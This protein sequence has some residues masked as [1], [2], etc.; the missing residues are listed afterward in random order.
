[1]PVI[2]VRLWDIER[3]IRESI[4]LSELEELLSNLKAE[5]VSVEGDDIYVEVSHDRA[6]LFSAEGIARAIRFWKSIEKPK[7]IN[8]SIHRDF[9]FDISKAPSYRPYAFLMI[10]K[11]VKLDDESIRQIF[12]LQ[13]K[14]HVTYCDD[15]RLVSI[16]LY[17]LDKLK[18][19]IRYIAV[20]KASFRPLDHTEAMSLDEILVKVDKGIKYGH[21]V[22]RGEY[23]LLVD[24]IGN[25]LSFPPIINCEDNRVTESTK[26]IVVDV[27]GTEPKLMAKII[28]LISFNVAERGYGKAEIELVPTSNEELTKILIDT[29]KYKEYTVKLNDI[30]DLIGVR[31]SIEEVYNSLNKSGY[32]ARKLSDEEVKVRV[33]PYRIDVIGIVD[34]IEDI[35]IGYG[36]NKIETSIYPPTH[37][38]EVLGLERFSDI[39]RELMVGLGFD[40]VLNF[41][42]IDRDFISMLTNEEFIDLANPKLKSYSAV[43]NSLIPSILSSIK[44]NADRYSGMKI[45]EIGDYVKIRKGRMKIE[46]SLAYGIYG[47]KVTL[48]DG[49]IIVKSLMNSL[50]MKYELRETKLGIFIE[51]RAAEV[52]VNNDVVGVVGELH[53][54]VIIKLGLSKPTVVGELILSRLYSKLGLH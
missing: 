11:N 34:I 52:L 43:R 54:E 42:L 9:I 8:V 31:M 30:E 32:I 1:M 4:L 15:R 51:G 40:E 29:L 2:N 12:Q 24:S 26:N 41:M 17:D 25:V 16:G 49:L 3:L 20:S 10:I 5:V 19:P 38:G 22:H 36:Y 28:T 33:P 44:R 7:E 39:I 47:D 53:P 18:P 50:N 13:E 14:L 37:H 6:D 46:R 21:L 23:P 45:F 35:A 27:T 48:T